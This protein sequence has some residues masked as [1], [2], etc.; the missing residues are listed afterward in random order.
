MNEYFSQDKTESANADL[1]QHL[2]DAL[3]QELQIH[4]IELEMQNETLRQTQFELE[5]SR[6]CYR[7]L[8][9]FAPVTYFTVNSKGMIVNINYTG[10][11]LLGV[12]RNKLINA[13]FKKYVI[14]QDK[15]RWE[16]FYL[17]ALNDYDI[18]HCEIQLQGIDGKCIQTKCSSR[19]ENEKQVRISLMDITGRYQMEEQLRKSRQMLRDLAANGTALLEVEIRHITL[20]VHEQLGQL[21][22]ALRMDISLLRIQFGAHDAAFLPKI[23]DMLVLVDLG[24]QRVRDITANFHPKA[25][26]MGILAALDYLASDFMRR[27]AIPCRL[28]VLDGPY[29]LNA[30]NTLSLFRIVQE[31]LSNISSYAQA[32]GVEISLTR[33]NEFIT[34]AIKDDGIGFDYDSI[35]VTEKYGLLRMKERAR[36]L[37][38]EVT[39]H[40]LRSTGTVITVAIPL[41]KQGEE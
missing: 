30:A 3:L 41:D 31:V 37:G 15:E 10:A 11:N 5:Q 6:D 7:D 12:E 40:S 19:V 14:Q 2:E 35:P 21:L 17:S 28:T 18:H 9:D 36:A 16:Q 22:S 39:I 29:Y 38:G 25:L 4:Q 26:D 34:V 13:S 20:E 8:Y 23:Q 33:E 24:I 32:A 1:P 27:T